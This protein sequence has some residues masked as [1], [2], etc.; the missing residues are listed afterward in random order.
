MGGILE[1]Q[2]NKKP[3]TS[4]KTWWG[5]KKLSHIVQPIGGHRKEGKTLSGKIL[6]RGPSDREQFK[7]SAS[8]NLGRKGG[9]GL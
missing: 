4:A 3:A 5:K 6:D 1:K 9:G 7:P 2:L 8:N